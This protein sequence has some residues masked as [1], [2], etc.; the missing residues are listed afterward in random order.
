[1][2]IEDSGPGMSAEELSR[3]FDP[4]YTTKRKGTGLGLA[5]AYRIIEK[6]RGTLSVRSQPGSG[7]LFRIELPL[8]TEEGLEEENHSFSG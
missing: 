1:M 7:T 4:F 3:I 2:E 5:I 6:H 8:P